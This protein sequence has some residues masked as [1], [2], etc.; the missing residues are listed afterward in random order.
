MRAAGTRGSFVELAR[1]D[2][3]RCF[4]DLHWH[5]QLRTP[6]GVMVRIVNIMCRKGL[7]N[8]T[9][10]QHIKGFLAQKI[11]KYDTMS[12]IPTLG[13]W[14]TTYKIDAENAV[15]LLDPAGVVNVKIRTGTVKSTQSW[16]GFTYRDPFN[17]TK[18]NKRYPELQD[19]HRPG[20][21]EVPLRD[22]GFEDWAVFRDSI[23]CMSGW[24]ARV[25]N[26]PPGFQDSHLA[27]T[28]AELQLRAARKL[29]T[30]NPR[31]LRFVLAVEGGQN[32]LQVL[33][34]E[35]AA[36]GLAMECLRNIRSLFAEDLPVLVRNAELRRSLWDRSLEETVTDPAMFDALVKT[37]SL[38]RVRWGGS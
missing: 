36:T 24:E 2:A 34:F 16:E 32:V 1:M 5:A 10:L 18:E 28:G 19:K 27:L 9:W 22:P 7:T 30:R 21:W 13:Q 20:E 8:N 35:A 4:R 12:M 25:E 37:I 26:L 11:P 29:C 33:V 31:M 38:L 23:R 15:E 6:H 17:Y 14:N 3:S